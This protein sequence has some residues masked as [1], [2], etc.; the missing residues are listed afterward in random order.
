MVRAK[1][2]SFVRGRSLCQSNL[3]MFNLQRMRN[4]AACASSANTCSA[5]LN[6]QKLPG[7]RQS[8]S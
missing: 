4:C 5:C 7:N 1:A 6:R 8:V 2:A 3:G